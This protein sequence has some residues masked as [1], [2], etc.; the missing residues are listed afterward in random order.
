MSAMADRIPEIPGFWLIA[1]LA[2]GTIAVEIAIVLLSWARLSRQRKAQARATDGDWQA[3][4]ALKPPSRLPEIIATLLPIAVAVTSAV[5]VQG[6]RNLLASALNQSDPTAKVLGALR[7]VN[8]ELNAIAM[9][10]W[11]T[12]PTFVAGCIAVALAIS[13]RRR[14]V[15]LRRAESL[16][17]RHDDASA[18]LKFPGP[19][20]GVLLAAIG[21]FIVLGFGPIARAGFAAIATT[22]SHFAAVTGLEP[23]DKGPI[24]LEGLVRASGLL[25]RG[26]LLARAG[27]AVAAVV[28]LVLA[29]GFSPARARAGVPGG[30]RPVHGEGLFGPIVALGVIALAV[31]GF[32]AAHR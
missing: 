22:I 10:L 26:F 7:A 24:F 25:D 17:A 1:A 4:A 13:A 19:R 18:W 8:G 14:A 9:G 16:A 6:S 3:I 20:A 12:P 29:W 30:S 23:Q 27:V 32:L 28:A 5:L 11:V 2:L 31:A 21:A 15:G